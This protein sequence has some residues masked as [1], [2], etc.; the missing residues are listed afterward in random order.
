M[1]QLPSY[2]NLRRWEPCFWH[3][4]RMRAVHKRPIWQDDFAKSGYDSF[5]SGKLYENLSICSKISR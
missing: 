2:S 4:G 3:L 1:G 5:F